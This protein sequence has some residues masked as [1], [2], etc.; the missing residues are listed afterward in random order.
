MVNKVVTLV[1]RS[2]HRGGCVVPVPVT[3]ALR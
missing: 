1:L 2:D 3:L